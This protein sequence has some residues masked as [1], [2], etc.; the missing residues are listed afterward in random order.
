MDGDKKT[1]QTVWISCRAN[2][3]CPGQQAKIVSIRSNAPI[4]RVAIGSFEA[5]QGG[6]TIR[7]RC[8]N[9]NGVFTITS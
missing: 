1:E 7:Y 9:C 3:E 6:Q 5:A 8:L 2:E 4:G